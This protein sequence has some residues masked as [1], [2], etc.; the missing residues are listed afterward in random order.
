MNEG[1]QLNVRN[2]WDAAREHR[3][4][5]RMLAWKPSAT[6]CPMDVLS[7]WYNLCIIY[8]TGTLY[9]SDWARFL[10][11]GSWCVEEFLRQVRTISNMTVWWFR[12]SFISPLGEMIRFDTYLCNGSKPPIRWGFKGWWCP[13]ICACRCGISTSRTRSRLVTVVPLWAT[14]MET[15][16]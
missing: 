12:R 10:R 4:A 1:K 6:Q 15:P 7:S 14:R 5:A 3:Q 8:A 11:L 2:A 16:R 13:L 9:V